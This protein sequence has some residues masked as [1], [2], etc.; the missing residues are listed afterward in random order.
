MAATAAKTQLPAGTALGGAM[1][2]WVWIHPTH[3][4]YPAATNRPYMRSSYAG[5]VPLGDTV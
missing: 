1:A 3:S 2:W 4:L 5:R